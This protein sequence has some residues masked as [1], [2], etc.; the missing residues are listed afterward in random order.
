MLLS[1]LTPLIG[2]STPVGDPK[3]T[4]SAVVEEIASKMPG[5]CSLC[6]DSCLL[7]MYQIEKALLKLVESEALRRAG[8][9]LASS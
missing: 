6:A 7:I 1:W 5:A 2:V 4:L 3:T 9:L 8:R